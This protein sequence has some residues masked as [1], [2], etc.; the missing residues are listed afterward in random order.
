MLRA[1]AHDLRRL[2]RRSAVHQDIDDEL[3]AYFEAAVEERMRTGLSRDEATRQARIEFGNP[4]V[5]YETARG[6]GWTGHLSAFLQSVREDVRF[7][8][9]YHSRA[10]FLTATM[11]VTL[12][13]GI[14]VNAALFVLIHSVLTNPMPGVARD[15][16]LVRIRARVVDRRN[17]RVG[18]ITDMSYPELLDYAQ[19]PQF[20][21]VGGESPVPVTLDP[22]HNSEVVRAMGYFVTPGYFGLLGVHLALGPGLPATIDSAAAPTPPMVVLGYRLWREQFAGDTTIIGQPITIHGLND[23][24]ATVVGIAPERFNG[25]HGSVGI[26]NGDHAWGDDGNNLWLPLSTMPTFAPGLRVGTAQF[27]GL[28]A[29]LRPGVTIAQANAAAQVIGGRGAVA[30]N[31]APRLELFRTDVVPLRGTNGRATMNPVLDYATLSALPLIILLIVCTNVS[32]LLVGRALARRREIGVRL[33]LGARRG[34]IVRQLLTESMLL[35]VGAGA[36]VVPLLW[37]VVKAFGHF[38]PAVDISFDWSAMLFTCVFALGASIVFGLSPALHASRASVADALKASTT[39]GTE[40]SRLQRTFVAAQVA[41]TQPVLVALTAIVILLVR[42][43]RSHP[44]ADLSARLVRLTVAPVRRAMPQGNASGA[45]L[46]AR[47]AALPGV[48]ALSQASGQASFANDQDD[49]FVVHPGDQRKGAP[50]HDPFPLTLAIIDTAYLRVMQ[51]PVILGRGIEG[52]DVRDSSRVL[53]IGSGLAHKLWGT[54]SPI[55][56]QLDPTGAAP[57]TPLSFTIVGVVDDVH[58]GGNEDVLDQAPSDGPRVFGVAIGGVNGASIMSGAGSD[59]TV[60]LLIRTT[61]PAATMLP[62]LRQIVHQ[63][64]PG[65]LIPTLTTIAAQEEAQRATMLH[66][67]TLAASGGLIALLLASIGLFAAVAFGIARRT[68]EIGIRM[69]LGARQSEVV[70]LFFRGG[71]G[72]G[73]IGMVVGLPLSIWGLRVWMS[74]A[75]ASDGSGYYRV[76]SI[77]VGIAVAIGVLLVT[78]LATWLPARRAA[79][80]DPMI[81]LRTE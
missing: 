63:E 2:F 68:R 66:I 20:S 44:S 80:V 4:T 29:R 10:P 31:G 56:K 11:I 32:S 38:A 76:S 24:I 19:Q 13:L 17:A 55:G 35:A 42:D 48:A 1:L 18:W 22:K 12:V 8:L 58:A 40:R 28:F 65:A 5:A 79:A 21:A 53:V 7:G 34:R 52:A 60:D 25:I 23:V 47:L 45:T 30:P 15:D 49:G 41:L 73:A 75:Q 6:A 14:G 36:I 51:L 46:S 77:T 59:G 61:V 81:S 64:M 43:L 50:P 16:A 70:R 72:L 57:E 9:R 78:A 39:G 27:F 62:T 26:R 67:T 3:R 33:S 37:W 69:A 71:L 74:T 54:E